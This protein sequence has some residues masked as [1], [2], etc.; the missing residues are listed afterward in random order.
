MNVVE[1][2][3]VLKSFCGLNVISRA[4]LKQRR[5]FNYTVCVASARL[6]LMRSFSVA[7]NFKCIDIVMRTYVF[8][9]GVFFIVF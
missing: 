2:A 5:R 3:L 1:I 8:S 4:F 7:S 6:N 9:Y